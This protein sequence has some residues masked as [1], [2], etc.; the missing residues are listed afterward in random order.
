MSVSVAIRFD[1]SSTIGSG[2]L[3]RSIVFGKILNQR[4]IK[5]CF[6]T[7]KS[8]IDAAIT[9]GVPKH[10]LLGFDIEVGESDWT[11]KLPDLDIVIVDFCHQE[12]RSSDLT[13][14]SIQNSSKA[15]ITVIDSMP[16]HH[17]L[18]SSNSVVSYVITPYLDAQHLRTEPQC[19]NWIT[20]VQY[21]ILEESYSLIHKQMKLDE[22]RSG[23]FILLCCGGSDPNR[24]TEYILRKFADEPNLQVE[25][26]VVVGQLIS[27]SRVKVLKKLAAK[28]P[29]NISLIFD[30]HNISKLIAECGVVI[31]S[32]GLIRYEAACLGKP[33]Y[34]IQNTPN[35]QN[36]LR[37][38]HNKGLGNIYFLQNERERIAFEAKVQSLCTVEGLAEINKPNQIGFDFVDG[39]GAQKIVD[40]LLE[41]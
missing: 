4:N 31:G 3:R 25:V 21:S 11:K 38:F 22:L 18:G 14:E 23:N 19:T 37:N 39:C 26:K 6:V 9:L 24:N 5:H 36:Y 12:H 17:Y 27:T 13:V 16:P 28:H 32:V 15:S 2:H 20:G 33:S 41:S 34:L 40:L 35:Y 1:V 10:A 8:S 7:E 29:R 30:C